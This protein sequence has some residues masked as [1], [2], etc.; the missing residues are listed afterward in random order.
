LAKTTNT[1]ISSHPP[2]VSSRSVISDDKKSSMKG[3]SILKQSTSSQFNSNS[4]LQNSPNGQDVPSSEL[5]F[6]STL[7]SGPTSN[8][9]D[10]QL[11]KHEK[12]KKVKKRKLDSLPDSSE[13]DSIV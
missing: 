13:N 2:P 11:R 1:I 8:S 12:M 6:V 7:P 4:I 10:N 9:Y 5:F 3:K